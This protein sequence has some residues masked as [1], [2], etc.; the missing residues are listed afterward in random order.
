MSTSQVIGARS[1][2]IKYDRMR[3]YKHCF[4]A[5]I[6]QEKQIKY[7]ILIQCNIYGTIIAILNINIHITSIQF[8]LHNC[9]N[10]IYIDLLS[11]RKGNKSRPSYNTK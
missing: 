11:P 4:I 1:N 3:S 10:H 9:W 7:N 2:I 5:E 8:S 6:K